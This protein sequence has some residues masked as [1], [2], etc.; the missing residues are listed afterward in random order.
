M[1]NGNLTVFDHWVLAKGFWKY[2][3][4]ENLRELQMDYKFSS[5]AD[6]DRCME[7]IDKIRQQGLYEHPESDCMPECKA[8]GKHYDDCDLIITTKYSA[9]IFHISNIMSFLLFYGF[10][11]CI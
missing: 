10:V 4:E 6:Y 9:A 3:V 11:Y 5:D 1:I 8:R 2:H 7:K